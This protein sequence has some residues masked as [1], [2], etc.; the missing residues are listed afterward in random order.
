MEVGLENET[1]LYITE[2]LA[3]DAIVMGNA[4]EKNDGQ[5]ADGT[6]ED[7]TVVFPLVGI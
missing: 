6:V 1:V 5:V 4:L 7:I 3:C 2:V